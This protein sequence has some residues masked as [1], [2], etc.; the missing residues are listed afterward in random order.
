MKNT[1]LASA[2][3]LLISGAAASAQDFSPHGRIEEFGGVSYSPEFNDELYNLGVGASLDFPFTNTYGVQVDGRAFLAATVNDRI[4][5]GSGTFT[6]YRR[7]ENYGLGVFVSGVALDGNI[8]GGGGLAGLVYTESVTYFGSLEVIDAEGSSDPLVG[9][10]LGGTFFLT[11]NTALIGAGSIGVTTGS[12]DG[13]I[14]GLS[15]GAE[16]RF[17][18]SPLS[19]GADYTLAATTDDA[20]VIHSAGVNLSYHFGTESLQDESQNGPG[21]PGGFSVLTG[22][23]GF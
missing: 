7:D 19:V 12:G 18:S 3:L 22:L 10:A 4:G 16:H 1:L 14:L 21:F 23:F 5:A 15:L 20:T 8:L 17:D 13:V 9:G 6:V 2:A 11:P